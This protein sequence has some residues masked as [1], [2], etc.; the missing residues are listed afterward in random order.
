MSQE[1]LYAEAMFGR[2]AEEFMNSEIGRYL[3]GCAEQEIEEAVHQLKHI[4]P[5]RTR[6]IRDIQAQI[7]RAE[8]FKQWISEAIVR[9]QQALQQLEVDE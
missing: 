3:T 5:W 2:D 7:W 8:S 6:K 1:A 4:H 9:G